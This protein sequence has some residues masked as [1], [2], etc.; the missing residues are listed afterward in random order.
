ML[1]K[2]VAVQGQMGLPL[3]LDEKIHI[4]KQQPD[5]VC[6]PEYFL[7]DSSITDYQRA[8]LRVQEH[9]E[10]YRQLSYEFGTC[11]IGGSVVEPDHSRLYNTVHVFD[12]GD[13]IG[14]YRKRHPVERERQN[15]ISPGDR[16]FVFDREDARAGVLICGDVFHPDRFAELGEHACD[17]IFVPT[18]SP[19]RPDDT[20]DAK[21]ERDQTYFVDGAHRSGAYVIKVCGVGEIFGRPLQGRS[22]IAAPWGLEQRVDFSAERDKRI[23][24]ATLDLHE[25]REF[26][27][28]LH[29]AADSRD[30]T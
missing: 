19:F 30:R 15:G 29:K 18:T 23:L 27:R 2:I 11:L 5:F 26:R 25:L 4:F 12:H 7:L 22:L 6:L 14:K 21:M 20:I 1:I 9:L 17:I 24:S 3:T 16:H 28:K 8:A 13:E 10:Y